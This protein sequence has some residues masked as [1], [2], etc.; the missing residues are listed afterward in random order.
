MAANLASQARDDAKATADAM[1]GAKVGGDGTAGAT[2]AELK[3]MVFKPD[4][5]AGVW[6]NEDMYQQ[7]M[8]AYTEHIGNHPMWGVKPL[9]AQVSV[10]ITVHPRLPLIVLVIHASR[11]ALSILVFR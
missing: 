4:R 10:H 5:H 6:G 7:A 1:K 11:A 3:K 9:K 8:T 2:E